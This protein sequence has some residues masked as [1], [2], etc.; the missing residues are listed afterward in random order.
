MY[1]AANSGSSKGLKIFLIVGFV[2]AG[3]LACIVVG[4]VVGVLLTTTTGVPRIPCEDIAEKT[5]GAL[6]YRFG[7]FSL[8]D[9]TYGYYWNGVC[10]YDGHFDPKDDTAT[11]CYG[12]D[13]GADLVDGGCY[14]NKES[15][16]HCNMAYREDENLCYNFAINVTEFTFKPTGPCEHGL[17]TGDFCLYEKRRKTTGSGCSKGW[18]QVGNNYCYK[19]KPIVCDKFRDDGIARKNCLKT[20]SFVR[21]RQN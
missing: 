2:G 21:D 4:V 7:N 16:C 19:R 20:A 11:G 1:V 8:S 18:D 6:Q 9:C 13:F 10:M 5:I 12:K 15:T 3:L 14:Y 17:L